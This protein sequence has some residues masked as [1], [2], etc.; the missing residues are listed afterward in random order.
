M[1]LT[2]NDIVIFVG[3][4]AA[5]QPWPPPRGTV[6]VAGVSP[7]I[8]WQNT[9]VRDIY[10][11]LAA[12]TGVIRTL[13]AVTADFVNWILAQVEPIPGAPGF[14]NPNG[15]ARGVCTDVIL[16]GDPPTVVSLVVHCQ[17]GYYVATAANMRKVIS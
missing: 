9:G 1:A 10:T 8:I 3:N 16:L 11:A 5:V 6:I 15:R 14:T 2:A 17:D 12:H 4:T 13:A 7:E